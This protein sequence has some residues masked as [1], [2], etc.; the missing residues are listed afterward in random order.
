LILAN[1][2]DLTGPQIPIYKMKSVIFVFPTA[3]SYY[4]NRIEKQMWSFPRE[5]YKIVLILILILLGP[6]MGQNSPDPIIFS[7][8][9]RGLFSEGHKLSKLMTNS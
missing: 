3:Q 5:I 4:E 2:L 1:S 7:L 9:G 6:F 8:K